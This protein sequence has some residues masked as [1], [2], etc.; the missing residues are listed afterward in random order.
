MNWTNTDGRVR[1]LLD[2]PLQIEAQGEGQEPRPQAL[3][4]PSRQKCKNNGCDNYE[5]YRD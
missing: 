5:R 2:W 4:E 3:L 1:D